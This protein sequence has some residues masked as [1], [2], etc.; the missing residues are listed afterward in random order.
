M[1]RHY[2]YRWFA[3]AVLFLGIGGAFAL[4][5]GLSRTPFGYRY[6]PSEFLFQAIVGPCDIGDSIL[7]LEFYG[8]SLEHLF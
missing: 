8:G 5:I 1:D 7:A 2:T 3:I 6:L 4:S